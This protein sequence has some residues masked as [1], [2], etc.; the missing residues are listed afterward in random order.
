MLSV[1]VLCV[2]WG[3]LFSSSVHARFVSCLFWAPRPIFNSLPPVLG[4]TCPPGV[5]EGP[6]RSP[7]GTIHT[8]K[9]MTLQGRVCAQSCLQ[10]IP[11]DPPRRPEGPSNHITGAPQGILGA[12]KV[13]QGLPKDALKTRGQPNE[14]QRHPSKTRRQP[15]APQGR[16]RDPQGPSQTCA[17][18]PKVIP[19]GTHRTTKQR[20]RGPHASQRYQRPPNHKNLS[21][22]FSSWCPLCLIGEATNHIENL[23]RLFLS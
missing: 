9:P 1:K 3:P 18:S 10:G 7:N 6:V 5:S 12:P 19:Q 13:P 20:P 17:R 21:I 4:L 14:P 16:P 23:M 8:V 15:K 11:I 22:I 2:Y